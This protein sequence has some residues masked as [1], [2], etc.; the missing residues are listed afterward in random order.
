MRI[1]LGQHPYFP[2]IPRFMSYTFSLYSVDAEPSA[3][4]EVNLVKSI[5]DYIGLS[6]L[7]RKYVFIQWC[8]VKK[9]SFLSFF[10]LFPSFWTSGQMKDKRHEIFTG[11]FIATPPI[12]SRGRPLDTWCHRVSSRIELILCFLFARD[13]SYK[14]CLVDIPFRTTNLR[15]SRMT[16]ILFYIYPQRCKRFIEILG[17]YHNKPLALL[18]RK[19]KPLRFV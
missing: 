4:F 9:A 12:K 10:S 2:G 14:L 3:I 5:T 11:H 17:G 15:F 1:Y 13:C 8:F 7:A 18:L 19:K 6:I 16:P